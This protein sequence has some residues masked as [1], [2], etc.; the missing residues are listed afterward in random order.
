MDF[1]TPLSLI[2]GPESV[3]IVLSCVYQSQAEL[4]VAG[5]TAWSCGGDIRRF[6][7]ELQKG[8]LT[9]VLQTQNHAI[10]LL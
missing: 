1:S 5:L 2:A 9:F 4:S 7:R 10:Y 6:G 3:G 8:N